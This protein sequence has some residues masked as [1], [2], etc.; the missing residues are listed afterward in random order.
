MKIAVI[1]VG[2]FD[3]NESI[4]NQV[5]RCYNIDSNNVDLYV[6]NNNSLDNNEKLSKYCINNK[7]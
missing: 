3:Y 7:Y 4:L 5:K 1:V 2:I 6:Y